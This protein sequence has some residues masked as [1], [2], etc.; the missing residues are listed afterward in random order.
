MNVKLKVFLPVSGR[1]VD[2][3]KDAKHAEH[4]EHRGGAESK[5]WGG[6]AN[7]WLRNMHNANRENGKRLDSKPHRKQG[8]IGPL[9][10]M[11]SVLETL[12][13]FGTD[14]RFMLLWQSAP[15]F[16]VNQAKGFAGLLEVAEL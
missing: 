15:S 13:A 10:L 9:A 4:H 12:F 1:A 2:V 16:G 5:P 8:L 3:E 7:D 14:A 11:R 6:F